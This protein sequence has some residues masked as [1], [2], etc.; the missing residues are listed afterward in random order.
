M[1][2]EDDEKKDDGVLVECP[3]CMPLLPSCPSLSVRKGPIEREDACARGLARFLCPPPDKQGGG[4]LMIVIVCFRARATYILSRIKIKVFFNK[5]PRN[6]DEC[7]VHI[8]NI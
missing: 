5:I 8:I 2:V 4:R 7:R 1:L 3:G 6:V